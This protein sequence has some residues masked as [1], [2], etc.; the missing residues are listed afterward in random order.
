MFA[1]LLQTEKDPA[2]REAMQAAASPA[3]ILSDPDPL[4]AAQGDRQCGRKPGTGGATG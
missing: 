1:R 2:V 4:G 3:P